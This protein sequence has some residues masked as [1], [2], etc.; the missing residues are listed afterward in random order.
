MLKGWKK[1][2][3]L[4]NKKYVRVCISLYPEDIENLKEICSR[5]GM[6]QSEVI[7]FLLKGVKNQEKWLYYKKLFE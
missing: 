1:N 3:S 7:R 6:T 5:S 4:K 2:M